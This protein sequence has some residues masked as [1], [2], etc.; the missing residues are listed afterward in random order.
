M[1]EVAPEPTVASSAPEVVSFTLVPREP[2]VD[3]SHPR[4]A[5]SQHRAHRV[6]RPAVVDT[7]YLAPLPYPDDPRNGVDVVVISQADE[8][9]RSAPVATPAGVSTPVDTTFTKDVVVRITDVQSATPSEI[10]AAAR[11][12]VRQA[13]DVSSPVPSAAGSR[14]STRTPGLRPNAF[15]GRGLPSLSAKMDSFREAGDGFV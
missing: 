2:V 14:E 9:L 5:S 13:E 7:P 8:T 12:S 3:N 11:L 10:L 1:K 15:M 4:S 6:L